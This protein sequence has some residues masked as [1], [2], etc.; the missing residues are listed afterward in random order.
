MFYP[1]FRST[2][3]FYSI[4]TIM[5]SCPFFSPLILFYYYFYFFG[6]NKGRLFLLSYIHCFTMQAMF[7]LSF[8]LPEACFNED[9]T[10]T[11][12]HSAAG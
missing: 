7:C 6:V 2:F 4:D 10:D 8:R 9:D 12:I 11:I 1:F 5:P 3:F